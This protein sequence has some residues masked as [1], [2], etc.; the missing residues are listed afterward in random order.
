[1]EVIKN[2]VL[3]K[4]GLDNLEDG[5]NVDASLIDT[6][7]SIGFII[8]F[9]I[10]TVYIYFI[11]FALVKLK[12]LGVFKVFKFLLKPLVLLKEYLLRYYLKTFKKHTLKVP[13]QNT[14]NKSLVLNDIE[15]LSKKI[16]LEEQVLKNL[17]NIM[18]KKFKYYFLTRLVP[19]I[20]NEANVTEQGNVSKLLIKKNKEDFYL[21]VIKSLNVEYISILQDYFGN[22]KALDVYI[23]QYF[24]YTLNHGDLKLLKLNSEGFNSLNKSNI[25]EIGEL[26]SMNQENN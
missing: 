17:D 8:D 20:Q 16:K 10:I 26:L 5:N 1:M 11:I 14:E 4:L 13:K 18:E 15:T 3:S 21:D 2:T 23:V 24:I 12:E 22:K 6:L 25:D 7:T 19:A 9:A